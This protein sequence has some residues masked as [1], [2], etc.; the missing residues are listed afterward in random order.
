MELWKK[1]AWMRM[2]VRY[3]FVLPEEIKDYVLPLKDAQEEID[4]RRREAWSKA[5]SKVC[6]DIEMYG[7]IKSMWQLGHVCRSRGLI[8]GYVPG[9]MR[10]VLGGSLTTA[11][12]RL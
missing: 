10:A 6:N 3:W 4:R 1:V 11:L 7:R 8:Y 2:H 12:R 9:G 5:W